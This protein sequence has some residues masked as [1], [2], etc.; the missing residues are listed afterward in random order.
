MY[1]LQIFSHP[2]VFFS[3]FIIF[4]KYSFF[5]FNEAQLIFLIAFVNYAFGVIFKKLLPNPRS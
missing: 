5:Y 3:F 2:V 4:L 1:D